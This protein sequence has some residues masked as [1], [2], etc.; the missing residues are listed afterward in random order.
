MAPIIGP[1]SKQEFVKAFGSFKLKEAVPDL[2]DN[3]WF[4]VDP[5]EPNRVWFFARATGTHT[6]TLNSWLVGKML[7]QVCLATKPLHATKV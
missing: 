3:S 5:L 2:A 4:Q 6:G 7:L 1:L